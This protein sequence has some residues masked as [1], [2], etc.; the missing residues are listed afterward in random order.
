MK[1]FVKITPEVEKERMAERRTCQYCGKKY[2]PKNARRGY[3]A[4]KGSVVCS[5][6]CS[7]NS[8]GRPFIKKTQP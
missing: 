4:F 6:E 2:P 5:V 3:L 1:K 8:W 7:R